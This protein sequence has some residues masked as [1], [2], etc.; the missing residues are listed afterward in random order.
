MTVGSQNQQA[1]TKITRHDL[2]RAQR[3]PDSNFELLTRSC[4]YVAAVAITFAAR[5]E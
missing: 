4:G 2:S 1:P 3:V 5:G